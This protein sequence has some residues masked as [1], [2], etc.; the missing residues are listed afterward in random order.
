MVKIPAK[1]EGIFNFV[2]SRPVIAPAAIPARVATIRLK[3]GFQLNP[4]TNN[5][6]TLPP[7]AKLPSQVISAKFNI[8][9]VIYI[10]NA[11]MAQ[12]NPWDMAPSIASNKF[13]FTSFLQL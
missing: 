9:N 2:C 4:A 7:V 3:N 8:R 10:P 12:N 13:I 5:P 11:K 6:H 1:M